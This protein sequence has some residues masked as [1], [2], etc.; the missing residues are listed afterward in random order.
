MK[1]VL[2]VFGTRPEAIKMAP[3]VVE[4]KRRPRAFDT[5]VCVTAQHREMLDQ[6]VT[7]FNIVPDVD[8]G[9]MTAGQDLF[10]VTTRV[11]N[12]LAEVLPRVKPDV[13]LVH[14]DT[15]TTFAAGLA[16]HYFR[17]PVAHV[18]AGLRTGNRYRPFPEEM[19]RRLADALSSLY[20]APTE[21]ARENLMREGVLDSDIV[22]TGN[23]VIDALL[24]TVD[25]V[26]RSP[27]ANDRLDRVYSSG[28]PIL[29]V[30]GHRRENLGAGLQNICEALLRIVQ[31]FPELY[32]VYPVHLNPR[33]R[34]VVHAQLQGTPNVL[35][36]EPLDYFQFVY[37]LSKCTLVLTDSG[38][39]QE[40]AP[41]LSK[42]VLVMRDG[43]ERPEG[44]AA[45]VLR[46][47]G[48]NP[49]RI[50]AEVERLLVDRTE[51]ARMS[52]ATNPFGDGR[53]AARIVDSLEAW[54]SGTN[55]PTGRHDD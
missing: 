44:V 52:S 26:R 51:Y 19:N 23:T 28:R 40:E 16:A 7:A 55:E 20:F 13:V 42:P 45:G 2:V 46:L 49:E 54:R 36:T 47:V 12:G 43:T 38:G 4:L 10:Q 37:L 35:L 8:L 18:E 33:V 25:Y 32:V 50:Y 48:T 41:S 22:V 29:L 3:V 5:V 1:K 34:S 24:H 53:A 21:R 14:G 15:T 11:L 9:I 31:R 27:P 17:I 39:I 6:V 30:T